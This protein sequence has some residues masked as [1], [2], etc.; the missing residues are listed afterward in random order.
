MATMVGGTGTFMLA[1]HDTSFKMSKVEIGRPAPGPNDVAID[2]HY[3]GMCHSDLHT[4]NGEWGV[5]KYPIAPGHEIGGVVRQVGPHAEASGFKVGD[6]VAVGCMVMSCLDCDLCK[7]G[8]EQ[9]CPKMC[10]TYSSQFPKGCDHDDCSDTHTN[11]GYSTSITVHKRFV[12]KVPEGM[13]LEHAGP[14][15]CAGITTY[16]PLARYIKGKANQTVGVVG[17]GGLGMMAVKIAKAMGASVTVFSR[18]DAKKAEAAALGADLVVQTDEAAIGALFRK[19][20]LIVDTVAMPHEIN[21]LISTLKAYTG[22]YCLIGGVPQP[23]Q[24]AAFPMIFNGT[25]VE[26]SLIGGCAPTQEML[27]FCAEHKISPDIQIID[28][29]DVESTLHQM[30]GAAL[31]AKRCVIKVDTIAAL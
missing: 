15:C 4:V 5:G 21:G 12:F 10:Q 7:Q 17:F 23:Y 8:L 6:R 27:D 18:S 22:M 24:L 11:G 28:A 2:I 19:F 3:C 30:H 13:A 9:H 29:K 26:G 14:L 20:D 31:G 1:A 16:S 25:R